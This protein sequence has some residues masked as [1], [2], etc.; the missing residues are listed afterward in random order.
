[1]SSS[2]KRRKRVRLTQKEVASAFGVTT[3]TIQRWHDE[4]FPREG[5]GRNTT[6]D[7]TECI[8]W[9]IDRER[10]EVERILAAFEDEDAS[11][12][13]KLAMQARKLELEVG[14]M[15]GRL[16]HVEDLEELH[17][18]PLAELRGQLL[19]IPGRL[20]PLLD[21]YKVQEA[22][23]ILEAFVGEF[24]ESLSHL[25]DVEVSGE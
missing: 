5:S 16:I 14:E 24:M 20:G 2:Q 12:K 7:L 10:E 4:G 21:R 18:A 11:R 6:Y 23:A 22:V 3:R 19:S 15:E 25:R 9:R 8:N 1:M 17:V 13:K